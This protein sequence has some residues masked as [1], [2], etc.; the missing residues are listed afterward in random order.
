MGGLLPGPRERAASGPPL[1]IIVVNVNYTSPDAPQWPKHTHGI[2]K[3]I[4]IQVF[5]KRPTLI[6]HCGFMCHSDLDPADIVI[7]RMTALLTDL[8]RMPAAKGLEAPEKELGELQAKA[9]TIEVKDAEARYRLYTEACRLR[10]QIMFKNP[11]LDFKEL[12]F[13][14]HHRSLFNHMCDQ[15]FGMAARPGGGLYI[16]SDPLGEKPELKDVLAK[17][18]VS[19]GRLKGRKL[20]GGPNKPYNLRFDG[21]GNLDGEETD[22][23]SFLSPELSYDGKTILFAYVE[24]TGNRRHD[25]HTDPS[26]GHWAEGRCYHIFRVNVDGSN[27]E[28]WLRRPRTTARRTAL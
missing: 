20:S 24:C 3:I 12:L 27:L 2:D 26:R 11:L 19:N 9:K 25:H 10:R 17:S 8:K 23:G 13:V 1:Q 15:Y 28:Q 5:A 6:F 22:G 21:E 14:K 16:L 4:H 18:T 7:R